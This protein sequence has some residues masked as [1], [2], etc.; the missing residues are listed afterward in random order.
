MHQSGVKGFG[1]KVGG[2]YHTCLVG[3]DGIVCCALRPAS[4]LRLLARHLMPVF[5]SLVTRDSIPHYILC[6]VSPWPCQSAFFSSFP[7]HPM[8]AFVVL[9][10]LSPSAR[11]LPR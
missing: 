2:C 6:I 10:A 7:R 4:R 9:C 8:S 5:S 3:I 1:R 11:L